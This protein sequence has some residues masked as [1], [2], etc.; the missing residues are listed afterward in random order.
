[1]TFKSDAKFK[2]LTYGFKYDMR[3]LV[4][5]HPTTQKS[6]NLTSMDYFC[7]NYMRFELQKYR[8]VIFCD[9]EVMQNGIINWVNFH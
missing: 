9:T 2:K 3:N 8:G 6:K 4:N 5:F 1:M 7:P